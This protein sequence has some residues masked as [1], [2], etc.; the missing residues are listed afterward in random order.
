MT[1]KSD[2][3]SALEKLAEIEK[4]NPFEAAYFRLRHADAIAKERAAATT[5]DPPLAAASVE[6]SPTLA[7]LEQLERED[8]FSAAA[9]CLKNI[10]Q[11]GQDRASAAGRM[12]LRVIE[13]GGGGDPAAPTRGVRGRAER[14]PPARSRRCRSRATSPQRCRGAGR[15]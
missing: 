3:R 4:T 10:E 1:T 5:D 9:F 13:G 7:K 6:A 8:P 15:K 2:T 12:P 11:I 14:E